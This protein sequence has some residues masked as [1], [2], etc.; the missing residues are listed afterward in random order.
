MVII[1]L[2]CPT[3]HVTRYQLSQR[4]GMNCTSKPSESSLKIRLPDLTG[5]LLLQNLQ[6]WNLT[7]ECSAT[8]QKT[9]I[10]FKFWESVPKT[11]C[12]E[13]CESFFGPH[14][15]F[16]FVL[17]IYLFCFFVLF[18]N[19]QHPSIVTW[20]LICCWAPLAIIDTHFTM[21]T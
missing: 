12:W 8:P 2:A 4:F 5:E 15:L 7:S 16:Y 3:S 11:K 21:C 13:K 19:W 1:I 18:S 9:L 10:L 6:W 20:T 17:F 14:S